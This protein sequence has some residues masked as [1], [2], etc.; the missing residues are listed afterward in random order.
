MERGQYEE[1]YECLGNEYKIEVVLYIEFK[2]YFVCKSKVHETNER[3]LQTNEQI[4]LHVT[5]SKSNLFSFPRKN[6]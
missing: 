4:G 3:T 6:I 1:D 5:T 2:H